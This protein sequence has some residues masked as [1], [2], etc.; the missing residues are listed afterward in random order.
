GRRMDRAGQ[1]R[2]RCPALRLRELAAPVPA[3][4]VRTRRA[5]LACVIAALGVTT[6]RADPWLAP[7]D[8]AL[9]SDI[10]LLADAGILHGPV[11]TWPMSWPDI[12]RDVVSAEV[13]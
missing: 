3:M 1:S 4:S 2:P 7:G 9:R 6:A 13:A 12:A 5:G 10:E 11:T 8:E